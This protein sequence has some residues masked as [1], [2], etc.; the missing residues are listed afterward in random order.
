MDCNHKFESFVVATL[1]PEAEQIGRSL[2][3][4]YTSEA[5]AR[6]M[7]SLTARRYLVACSKCGMVLGGYAASEPSSFEPSLGPTGPVGP[8]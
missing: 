2:Q 1:P 3:T 5:V 8:S 7:E 4:T 6:I